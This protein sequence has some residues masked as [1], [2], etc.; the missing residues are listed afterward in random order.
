M[1]SW[2]DTGSVQVGGGAEAFRGQHQDLAKQQEDIK[3]PFEHSDPC[4]SC[5]LAFVDRELSDGFKKGDG[6]H[7][8]G[9]SQP[10]AARSI[11]S[12]VEKMQSESSD[13]IKAREMRN[14]AAWFQEE[15]EKT[16]IQ[17]SLEQEEWAEE[18]MW[19]RNGATDA[20]V[21]FDGPKTPQN[22]G[23]H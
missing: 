14:L 5:T 16:N 23:S 9:P 1:E 20:A 8:H 17:M 13:A 2:I 10:V 6:C 4:G 12:E 3:R 15:Y 19:I 21:S 18:L 7:Q 22:E 11:A